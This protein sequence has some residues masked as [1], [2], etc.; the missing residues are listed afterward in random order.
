MK[1]YI[2]NGEQLTIPQVNDIAHEAARATLSAAAKQK[3]VRARKLVEQW[4]KNGE[5]V[6]GITTGFGEFANV[7][8]QAEDIEQLQEN[9][10]FSHAAGTGEPLPVE[11]VRA[12]M[13]LR[14]NALA[15]GF[16]GTKLTTV[17]LLIDMLNR[18]IIPVI[19]SQGSV[20]AS[21][22]LVQLAHLVLAMMGKGKVRQKGTQGR[23]RV[24]QS[25][26]ALR[27]HGLH[28]VRLAAKEGLALI[29]GTQMMTA[30]AALAVHQAKLL[31]KIADIAAS[32]SVEALRG[33]DTKKFSKNALTPSF[34]S[35]SLRKY[36][37]W[38]KNLRTVRFSLRC[39]TWIDICGW[40]T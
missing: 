30:Y 27:E 1:T 35:K 14:V 17:Q 22:D 10:I 34:G 38:T 8:I 37:S 29:N 21:G 11:V 28:P 7:R 31:T 40:A 15:K 20:G 6:Y 5:L 32:I 4:T 2:L 23:E 3:I 39:I 26:T 25:K 13:V 9:L 36:G 16:S 19:P 33:S 12:M 18:D 24:V